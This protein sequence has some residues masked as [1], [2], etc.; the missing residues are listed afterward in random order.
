M[1]QHNY[2]NSSVILNIGKMLYNGIDVARAWL[3]PFITYITDISH[4]QNI[5]FIQ[6]LQI[7]FLIVS[8][9]FSYIISTDLECIAT[10]VILN[11]MKSII[12]DTIGKVC[13]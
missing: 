1:R 6:P 11:K 13:A 7:D 3:H 8:K 12:G 2:D 10:L 4:R 5:S 9:H